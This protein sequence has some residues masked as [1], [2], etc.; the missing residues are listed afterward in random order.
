MWNNVQ[1]FEEQ[2]PVNIKIILITLLLCTISLAACARSG[3]VGEERA[4]ENRS[5]GSSTRSPVTPTP[6]A[7]DISKPATVEPKKDKEPATADGRVFIYKRELGMVNLSEEWT[8]YADGSLVEA[9][10]E[11][12]KVDPEQ[13]QMVLEMSKKLRL[14]NFYVSID[15]CCDLMIHTVT[16]YSDGE[17]K[18]IVTDDGIRPPAD[19]T[20]VIDE[21]GQLIAASRQ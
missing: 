17:T 7:E 8:I 4:A 20:A 14:N 5:A 6:S 2:Q 13:V 16:I 11:E 12:Q 9:D 18:K 10:G 1:R 19:V 15:H 21:L 3:A